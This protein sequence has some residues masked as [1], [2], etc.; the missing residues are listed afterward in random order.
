MYY[1]KAR[2]YSPTLG[3]FMPDPIGYAD[4][5][6]QYAYVGG[7]PVNFVDPLG[8]A[9][10]E[11][12]PDDIIVTGPKKPQVI[13]DAC[14]H[15]LKHSPVCNGGGIPGLPGLGFGEPLPGDR[16]PDGPMPENEQ[17]EENEDDEAQCRKLSGAAAALCWQR[18]A[19]RRASRANGTVPGPLFP[20][21]RRTPPAPYDSDDE[22][23]RTPN[24]TMPAPST[25]PTVGAILLGIGA[26]A[27]ALLSWLSI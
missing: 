11:P 21:P 18:A 12:D 2:L 3:R 24:G 15:E 8:L 20:G 25:A 17:D 13:V 4:G 22:G 9:G 16:L 26:A 19:Q 6:N 27:L 1:Y 14:Q 23:G 5:M 7:D 10:E